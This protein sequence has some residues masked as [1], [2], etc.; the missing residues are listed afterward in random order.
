MA[1]VKTD[2]GYIHGTENLVDWVNKNANAHQIKNHSDLHYW[3]RLARQKR[4][5]GSR[6]LYLGQA[7][8]KDG[9]S[10]MLPFYINRDG[11]TFHGI[12]H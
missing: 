4:S 11:V 9:K 8:S 10:H 2:L 7:E 1:S 5:E 12:Y 6:C 3:L